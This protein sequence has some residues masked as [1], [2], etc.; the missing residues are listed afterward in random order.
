M[1]LTVEQLQA[2][3]ERLLQVLGTNEVTVDNQTIRY[4]GDE[5][6]LRALR[7]IDAEIAALQAPQARQFVIQT[8]RGI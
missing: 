1:A 3:R 6:K 7:A 2:K 4:T 8:K 5:D